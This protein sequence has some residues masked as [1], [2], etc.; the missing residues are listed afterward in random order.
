MPIHL[1]NSA[2][3]V[4]SPGT[5][6]WSGNVTTATTTILTATSYFDPYLVSTG[7]LIQTVDHNYVQG[8]VSD[9]AGQNS[10]GY[11]ASDLISDPLTTG[12]QVTRAQWTAIVEDM[13]RISIHQ[14]GQAIANSGR[15]YVTPSSVTWSVTTSGSSTII[16]SSGTGLGASIVVSPSYVAWSVSSGGGAST[17]TTATGYYNP[18]SSSTGS[19]VVIDLGGIIRAGPH[20]ELKNLAETLYANRFTVVDSQLAPKVTTSG[21][22]TR[23]TPWDGV[24]SHVALISWPNESL[25]NYFFNAGGYLDITADQTGVPNSVSDSAWSSLINGLSPVRFTRSHWLSGS[26]N[27]STKLVWSGTEVTYQVVAV[28]TTASVQVT[29]IFNNTTSTF[30]VTP[31]AARWFIAPGGAGGAAIFVDP[32]AATWNVGS[33]VS[34]SPASAT[35]YLTT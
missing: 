2:S 21:E 29:S 20:N 7:T 35:W 33:S 11:G 19:D 28:K 18:G 26:L 27:T 9:V 22:S 31:S 14:T 6:T 32:N 15:I 4:V 17:I 23:F 3:I 5:V 12:T 8:I 34:V 13:N 16:G 1:Q 24:I 30:F 10:L 25:G